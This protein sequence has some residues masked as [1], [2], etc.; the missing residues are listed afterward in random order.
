MNP[1]SV[2]N[3][4]DEFHEFMNEEEVDILFMSESWERENLSLDQIIKLEKL[5]Q[6]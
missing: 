6:M 1:R 3:K 5:L 2:Y 4:I